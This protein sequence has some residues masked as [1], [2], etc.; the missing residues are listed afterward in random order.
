[1]ATPK[2]ARERLRGADGGPLYVDV[3]TGARG[4]ESRPVVIICHGFKG[5][6]DWGMFPRVAERLA[7]AGFTAVTFNFSGSGVGPDS[8]VVDEPERWFRQTLTG[9]LA[10]LETVISHL[11]R[12][13][14]AWVGLVGHSRGGGVA[15]LQAARDARVKALV[16]WGAVAG[17]QRYSPEDL[18]RW[19]RDG[20]LDVVNARTGQV[21]PM[22]PEALEDLER[23]ASGTLDVLAA[24]RQVIVPWLIVHGAA[25]ESVPKEEAARLARASG[26]PRT[27]LLE[28]PGAGHTFGARHPWAGSPPELEV[29]VSHT[30]QFL[31]ST[32]S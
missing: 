3:R 27:E 11:L 22:G 14:P 15:V 19:R 20:H 12:D 23:N 16:T 17:F 31:G 1:M 32:L 10:D 2:L 30:S 18:A 24:A 6:K 29:V 25:D 7:L 28:V 9:D 21:L 8:D 13:A 4:R 5:F 26:S